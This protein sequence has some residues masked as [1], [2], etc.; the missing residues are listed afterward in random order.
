MY[1]E[2]QLTFDIA[3]K[4]F[5]SQTGD[6]GFFIGDTNKIYIT[7]Q[8]KEEEDY[9]VVLNCLTS[10]GPVV[11]VQAEEQEDGTYLVSDLDAALERIG[12]VY[13]QVEITDSDETITIDGSYFT[14]FLT[15][16]QSTE[17]VSPEVRKLTEF[18][19][20]LEVLQSIDL[21][22]IEEAVDIIENLDVE[23]L[24]SLQTSL[25]TLIA[26]VQ[27]DLESGAFDGADGEDGADGADGEDGVSP[28]AT[29]SKSGTVATITITDVNGTTTAEISDGEKGDTGETGATGPQGPQGETGEAGADGADGEDGVSPTITV[30]SITGGHRVVITDVNGSQTFDI[31]DGED[32]ET[33]A[34]GPQGE[35]GEQGET[36]ATGATGATG[37]GIA[38][39]EKTSTSGLVDTYTITFTDGT[40]TTFDVTN[41]ADGAD[42][43]D[44]DDYVLT[45]TDKDEIAD[46]VIAY[47]GSADTTSF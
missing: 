33:G 6:E 37:N 27:E 26:T 28:T 13:Y 22:E 35:Q 4:A 24:E 47:I 46:I 20:A 12:K 11:S 34:T 14:S 25:E 41:G 42:G 10:A 21:D 32:G 17:A 18:Y 7:L 8:N 3:S 30:T 29:V 39:I 44:G 36:G 16:G 23:A 40:T 1:R 19:E 43:A 5:V 45:D 9:T 15:Y 38:S 31:M 2:I